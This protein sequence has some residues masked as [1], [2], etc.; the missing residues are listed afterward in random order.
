MEIAGSVGDSTSTS[1]RSYSAKD[2]DDAIQRSLSSL[3]SSPDFK[4]TEFQKTA[5]TAC[6]TKRITI[7]SL[8]T[9]YGKTAI[10]QLYPFVNFQLTGRHQLT[11]VISPLEALIKSQVGSLPEGTA[12]H[13]SGDTATEDPN[14]LAARQIVGNF[15][16]LKERIENGKINFLYLCPESYQIIYALILRLIEYGLIAN[17]VVDENHYMFICSDDFRPEFKN[18]HKILPFKDV[19]IVL[20]SGTNT[21]A[22]L[23]GI[24]FNLE[25][26]KQNSTS[27][28]NFTICHGPVD[29]PKILLIS[30]M[31]SSEVEGLKQLDIII[32]AMWANKGT[33]LEFSPII[34]YTNTTNQTLR[35]TSYLIENG[36]P[37]FQQS[38]VRYHSQ[39]DDDERRTSTVDNF[40]NAD[41]II[42]I[43]VSTTALGCGM[44]KP[45][46]GTVICFTQQ[47]N[48]L[49]MIQMLG[50]ACRNGDAG[51]F[52]MFCIK[53]K[54]A[55]KRRKKVKKGIALCKH[56]FFLQLAYFFIPLLFRK[57]NSLG[58]Y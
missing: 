4:L 7:I 3:F 18:L 45:N 37:S 38:I 24:R 58:Y 55:S 11:I 16:L 44:N 20:L 43:V 57:R 52:I 39:M 56:H 54:Q 10:F 5:I 50:R 48:H 33:P 2:I 31:I 32:E 17:V 27:P 1:S 41:S 12:I 30:K 40:L 51:M 15:E 14:I 26:I 36:P 47:K 19:N 21:T 9:G 8:G 42:R 34:I 29:R 6:L 23:N 53:R 46:V 49:E 22:V 13:F 28:E 35:V 25:S